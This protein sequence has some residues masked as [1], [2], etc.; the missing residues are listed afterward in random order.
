MRYSRAHDAGP[1][2]LTC[3]T[4]AAVVAESIAR[5]FPHGLT[6]VLLDHDLAV[7]QAL[8]LS[9]TDDIEEVAEIFYRVASEITLPGLSVVYVSADPPGGAEIS[10]DAVLAWHRVRRQHIHAG[11]PVVD[12]LL[13]HKGRVRSMA[14]TTGTALPW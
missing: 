7:L 3:A 8:P 2:V 12:W 10:E 11:T 4:D 14:E 13:V 6:V 9:D 1:L 5:A